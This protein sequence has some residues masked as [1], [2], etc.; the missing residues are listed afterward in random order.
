M[1]LRL[2]Q[3]TALDLTL[4]GSIGSFRVGT[5]QNG[6]SSLEVKYLLTHVGL[7]FESPQTTTCSVR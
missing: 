7:N 3:E 5:G 6:H 1:T 2:R 4:E